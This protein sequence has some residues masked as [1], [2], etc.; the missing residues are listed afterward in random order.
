MSV[1][2]P[3]YLIL[4]LITAIASAVGQTFGEVTGTV[5]DSSAAIVAGAVVTLI[6]TETS[7]ARKVET[8]ETGNYTIPFVPPGVYQI[9]VEKPGFKSATRS[10]VRVQVADSVRVNFAIEVG[11][12][13]ESI[14]VQGGT[15]LLTTENATVGTVIDNRRI[16]ELPLNGRNYLQMVSLSPN[17]SAEQGAGG[18]AAARKGGTPTEKS[19]SVAGARNQFNHYAR[20]SGE[21]RHEL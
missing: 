15:P 10:D 18:E 3:L 1:R 14:E 4:C 20:R 13:S 17:V 12:V 6:N 16:V 7:Q 11:S 19:I 2:Q 9:R 21:H 5:S 8:N